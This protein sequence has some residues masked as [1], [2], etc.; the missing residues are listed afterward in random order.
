[1]INLTLTMPMDIKP[2]DSRQIG[3]QAANPSGENSVEANATVGIRTEAL[4]EL[5]RAINGSSASKKG[6]KLPPLEAESFTKLNFER[7]RYTA[8]RESS[9]AERRRKR[10][11]SPKSVDTTDLMKRLLKEQEE[12]VRA[13][14][15]SEAESPRPPAKRDSINSSKYQFTSG[16]S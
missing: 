7:K 11:P 4:Y 13:L 15:L 1:V 10:T 14:Q 3:P 8:S 16:S 6:K 9:S 2:S 12:A 5:D